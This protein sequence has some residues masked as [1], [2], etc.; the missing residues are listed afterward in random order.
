MYA[1]DMPIWHGVDVASGV[2]G[3]LNAP[4]SEYGEPFFPS[5]G[6]FRS[7][8]GAEDERPGFA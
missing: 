1:I 2:A 5:A 7:L 4:A 3:R 6:S 8:D